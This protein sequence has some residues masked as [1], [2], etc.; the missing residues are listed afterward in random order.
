MMCRRR[1]KP[2]TVA[3]QPMRRLPPDLLAIYHRSHREKPLQVEGPEEEGGR[4][5]ERTGWSWR[6]STYRTRC[7]ETE[8][9]PSGAAEKVHHRRPTKDVHESHLCRMDRPIMMAVS[10]G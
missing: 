9:Q 7:G 5:T 4:K 6:G 8:R 2:G 3:N 10:P 1:K